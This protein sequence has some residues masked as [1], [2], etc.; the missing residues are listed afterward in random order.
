MESIKTSVKLSSFSDMDE[1]QSG[2]SIADSINAE[3]GL[4][5]IFIDLGRG[6]Y[7]LVFQLLLLIEA[8]HKIA[9]YVYHTLQQ[10]EKVRIEGNWNEVVY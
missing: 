3:P 1:G 7:R 8:D 2:S 6:L 9:I 4:A 5:E 10:N